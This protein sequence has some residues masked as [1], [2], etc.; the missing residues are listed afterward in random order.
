MN[1]GEICT[2]HPVVA[3]PEQSVVDAAKRMR[4]AHVG[5]VVVVRGSGAKLTPIGILTDRDITV[6]VVAQAPEVLEDITIGELALRDLVT[7]TQETDVLDAVRRMRDTAV[8]RLPVVDDGGLL[9][10]I[11]TFDDILSLLGDEL[12]LL[13]SI[14]GAER[15]AE[16]DLRR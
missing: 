16:T 9:A 15:E 8:R 10:G 6:S 13:S 5:N 11:V 2:R 7:V 12:A 1:V 14:V 3:W 4:A